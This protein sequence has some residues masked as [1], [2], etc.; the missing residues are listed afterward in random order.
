MIYELITTDQADADVRGIFEYIA[1]ELLSPDNAVGQL[2]R[3]EEHIIGLEEFP[4]KF[5]HYEKEPW[6]SR[7]LRVMPVD[8]YLVFYIPN[9][10]AEIVTA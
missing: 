6:H 4:E 7:G 8:N 9:K 2:E 10:D 5:R 1:Y 3:L